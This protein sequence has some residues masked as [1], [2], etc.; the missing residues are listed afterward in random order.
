MA[1]FHVK[2]QRK[3]WSMKV[4]KF[5]GSSVGHPDRIRDI[6]AILTNESDRG[7]RLAVVVS[8]FGGGTDQLIEMAR[9]AAAGDAAWRSTF[10][11]FRDRHDEAVRALTTGERRKRL[12]ADI[13]ENHSS[14]RSLLEGISM[15]REASARSMDY[16]LSFGERNSAFI[17]SRALQEAGLNA[18]FLDARQVI[19]TDKRFGSANVRFEETYEH[20]ANHFK[21]TGG[22]QVVTGFIAAHTKGL[23][24]TLGRGG[25]DYTAALLAAGLKAEAIEIWTDVDG[26]MTADP[27]AVRRA[28]TIPRL[29]YA[30]AMEMS[31]FGAKVIYPPTLLP[32]MQLGIP[33]FIKNTFRPSFEGTLV[34]RVADPSGRAVK[35]ISS[36]KDVSLLTLEGSGM[37]GVVGISGRLFGT[38][39]QAGINVILITQGSSEHNITF[40]VAPERA[41]LAKRKV[42]TAF[43]HEIDSG[44]LRPIKVESRLSVI[45]VIGE[46]MRFKPGIAGRLFQALGRNGIN[47]VA[48]A[49]GS[50]ELNISVVIRRDDEKKALN[51]LH[52]AF[53]L[54]DLRD[55]NLFLVGTGL[56]AKELLRQMTGQVE[57]L[58][59]SKRLNLRLVGLTN[60]RRMVLDED[61]IDIIAWES[62]L[63][64]GGDV[65]DID[66]FVE[67][68]VELNL[69]NSIFVDCSASG[70]VAE[71]YERLLGESI[72]V[73]TPNKVATSSSHE[74]YLNLKQLAADNST[75]FAYETNVGAGLPIIGTL[76]DLGASGDRVHVIQGIL[77]GSL[78]YIFNTFDGSRSFSEVVREAQQRGFTEPD[79][80]E[81]LSGKDVARKLVILAREAGI[82]LEVDAVHVDP[83][84]STEALEAE[85]TET[86]FEALAQHDDARFVELSRRAKERGGKLVMLG[87]IRDG[88]ASVGLREVDTDSPFHGMS[89]SDNMVVFHTDR[90]RERPLVIR[91]PGAGASV[92]AAGVFAEII[93]IG[94]LRSWE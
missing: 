60:S 84:L 67:R 94:N 72:A 7:E 50:S 62:A 1:R 24:T 73:S 74:R 59:E 36:L 39:A 58:R 34:T 86:F 25:S 55:V 65:A 37:F 53:F 76:H 41:D 88:S 18:Q 52:D 46:Q 48:I 78:S 26:V 91:G 20:I 4:L 21:T 92:T 81:D 17:I 49:Q 57:R 80:R 12:L 56:I 45:A 22:I 51:A 89:G 27:R 5:G 82:P 66:R 14:L 8:A 11:R 87:E 42:E 2:P 63:S 9:L 38:L 40:A 90:Y 28:F 61:G 83:L 43:R 30:E 79:P 85:S 6:I 16:V 54:S 69:S 47:C 68:A 15:V 70:A 19:K 29:S 13:R 93:T 64:E 35:G 77:S 71:R 44:L 23:T 75:V 32:A 31:H 10:E 3:D 33:L